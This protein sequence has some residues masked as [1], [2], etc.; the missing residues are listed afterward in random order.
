MA[1]DSV[2]RARKPCYAG[3]EGGGGRAGDAW[4]QIHQV[5]RGFQIHLQTFS[6]TR[7]QLSAFAACALGS[8]RRWKILRENCLN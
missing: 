3:A 7:S 1:H 6:A 8:S 5:L 4:G 2:V